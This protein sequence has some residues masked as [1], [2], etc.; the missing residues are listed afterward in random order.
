VASA[1]AKEAPSDSLHRSKQ[2]GNFKI[3]TSLV[4]IHFFAMR[5][6]ILNKADFRR[7]AV[8]RHP[9]AVFNLT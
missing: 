1:A 4:K 8:Q 9:I 2:S 7:S 6:Q 5:M 3:I